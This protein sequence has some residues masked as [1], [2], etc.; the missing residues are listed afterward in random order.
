MEVQLPPLHAPTWQSRP[1]RPGRGLKADA[2]ERRGRTGD[3]RAPTGPGHLSLL[4][5]CIGVSLTGRRQRRLATHAKLEDTLAHVFKS[6][7]EFVNEDP[8]NKLW[9]VEEEDVSDEYVS[10]CRFRVDGIPV[11]QARS[12]GNTLRRTLLRQDLFR[13][14]APVAFR[15]RRRSFEVATGKVFVSRSQPALHEY[16]S[17][18]GVQESMIDVVRFVQHLAVAPAGYLPSNLPLAAEAP[19]SNQPDSWRWIARRCGPCAVRASDLDA[20]DG[21]TFYERPMCLP[22]DQHLLTISAPAIIE[23]EVEATCCSQ[24]EWEIAPAF[25]EYRQRLRFDHWLMVPPLFS[26]VK[27]VNYLITGEEDQEVLQLEVWT[28]KSANASSLLRLASASL[29]A[30]LEARKGQISVP[31]PSELPGMRHANPPSGPPG[32]PGLAAG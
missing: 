4:I 26:P 27:K 15:L 22:V 20:I 29:L 25:E 2:L 21:S 8:A 31:E 13:S 17:V 6:Y 1:T 19:N 9:S 24:T 12:V 32:H 7:G 10:Y 28:T 30:G 3:R 23:F 14:V 11:R 16:A 18:P 5:P